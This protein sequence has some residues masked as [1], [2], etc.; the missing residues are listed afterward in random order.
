MQQLTAVEET[1]IMPRPAT[2]PELP[3]TARGRHRRR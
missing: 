1:V 2:A 3:M